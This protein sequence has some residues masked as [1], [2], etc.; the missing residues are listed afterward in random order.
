VFRS[1]LNQAQWEN[2][3]TIAITP[4]LMRKIYGA[5]SPFRPRK[6]VYRG[7]RY[8]DRF[9]SPHPG[10]YSTISDGFPHLA[11]IILKETEK[12]PKFYR[13]R[14]RACD[15]SGAGQGRGRREFCQVINPSH[16][17]IHSRCRKTVDRFQSL[18]CVVV[19]EFLVAASAQR[20]TGV[21]L[22]GLCNS[23]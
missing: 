2:L 19:E 10:P 20:R 16:D 15:V 22:C 12:R 1:R 14:R 9:R 7:D 18:A 13:D 17:D 8:Q 23:V 21:R 3:K 11:T 6:V 4:E 5:Q